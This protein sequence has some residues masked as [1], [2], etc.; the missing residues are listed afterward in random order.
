MNFTALWRLLR[1]LHIFVRYRLDQ[2]LLDL[3]LPWYGRL[4]LKIG[5]WRLRPARATLHVALACAGPS[6]ISVR[7]SSSSVRFSPRAAT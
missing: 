6:K 7:S 5:P 1:I 2:L 3:P 4:L